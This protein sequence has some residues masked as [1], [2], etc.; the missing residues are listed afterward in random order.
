MSEIRISVGKHCDG[1]SVSC[2]I[3]KL[4]HLLAAGGKKGEARAYLTALLLEALRDKSPDTLRVLALRLDAAA[5]LP[6]LIC[7]VIKDDKEAEYALDGLVGE[8]G[9]RFSLLKEA[10]VYNI[11][12]YNELSENKLFYIICI[13]GELEGLTKRSQ[14]CVAAL[15][16]KARAA[17]I[18]LLASTEKPNTKVI[19]GII[20]ANIPS[21][22]AL[23]TETKAESRLILDSPGAERLE[24][25]EL[26]FLPIGQTSPEKLTYSVPC[27][28]ETLAA[29]SALANAFPRADLVTFTASVQ[30]DPSL[31]VQALE[32]ALR[33]GGISTAQLQRALHIGYKKAAMLIKE[34]EAAGYIGEYEHSSPRKLLLTESE[35]KK[36][37]K[38]L[39]E[40]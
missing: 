7:P 36:L 13:I 16:A 26:L 1:T 40:I 39:R 35:L 27:G 19:T 38:E 3:K 22:I 5:D 20:K 10:G 6:H 4:P 21:R 9:R 24:E 34:M 37:T 18:Y 8:T 30:R 33:Y 29:L 11:D 25:N 15:A 23:K 17:G 31:L 12:A 14:E 2:D 28:K 32:T